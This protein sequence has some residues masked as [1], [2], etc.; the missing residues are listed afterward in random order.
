MNLYVF[1]EE[2]GQNPYDLC[3]LGV[4]ASPKNGYG[5]FDIIDSLHIVMMLQFSCRFTGFVPYDFI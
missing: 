5:L 1:F 2:Y 3:F 4:R